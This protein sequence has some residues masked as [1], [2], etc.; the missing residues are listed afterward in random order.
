[1]AQLFLFLPVPLFSLFSLA[2]RFLPRF[3]H[4]SFG[5]GQNHSRFA[6]L[7]YG[8]AFVL[9]MSESVWSYLLIFVVALVCFSSSPT[10]FSIEAVVSFL[11]L[12]P[13]RSMSL[14]VLQ[15]FS[16]I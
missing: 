5:F 15:A 7:C 3:S 1:M 16:R 11:S 4:F 13:H 9:H 6:C 14:V 8:F 10:V 2:S 12:V